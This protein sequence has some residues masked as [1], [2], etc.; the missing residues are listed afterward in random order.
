M[1]CKWESGIKRRT[2][3]RWV[4]R[5]FQTRNY[6]ES[7]PAG[8]RKEEHLK[9]MKIPSWFNQ[10]RFTSIVRLS[11][12]ATLI[13]VGVVSAILA[14]PLSTNGSSTPTT[15]LAINDSQMQALSTTVGGAAPLPTARTVAHWFGT[16][17]NPLDGITYGFNMVGANPITCSG[18]ACDVTITVD[19][20]PLIVNVGGQSFDGSAAL[21]ATLASPVFATNDYGSVPFATS[22]SLNP[23]FPRGPGGPLSQLDAGNLLQLQ[24]ATMRAQFNQVG[25]SNFHLRLHPVVHDTVTIDVPSGK[26]TIIVSGRGVL[27]ADINIQW[28]STRIQ[29][30]NNSLGYNDPT[31]LALYLT[32]D[33]VNF[34]GTDPGNCCVIGF[35]GAAE[36]PSHTNN[37]P[38]LGNGN[39]PVQTFAWGSY[40]SP[41]L[42]ARAFPPGG[43]GAVW[44][45]QDIHP[46]SH[47]ISEWAD[48]PFINNFVQ[49]WGTP[50]AQSGGC[51]NL[52]ETG[53][54]VTGIGFAIGT[55]TYLQGPNPNGTQSADGFYH[56][57]DEVYLPW[58]MRLAP[59]TISEP[60][61]TPTTNIGRYTFMG[62]LNQFSGFRNPPGNCP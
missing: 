32:Q 41:G 40:T 6:Q 5:H 46:L 48:D 18:S 12:A 39:Q 49:P 23:R 20:T 37:G 4:L 3:P 54:P 43:T 25:A 31:H 9:N 58:F 42:F 11:C 19:I 16:A 56:P 21:A 7:N 8:K 47:E 60:T 29:E 26:G 35:H 44:A 33:T 62:L 51:S 52:L 22:G 15:P 57:E 24:D 10:N 50:T 27:A 36:V 55:N 2:F 45:L 61:Q 13:S 53:D 34:E 17:D 1:H 28:W 38:Q 59:N 30:L 14:L